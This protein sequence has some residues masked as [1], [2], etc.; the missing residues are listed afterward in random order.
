MTLDSRIELLGKLGDKL[1]ASD[2]SLEAVVTK[3]VRENPWFTMDSV[4]KSFDAIASQYL[5]RD[6]LKTWVSQYQIPEEDYKRVA[7][8]LAGNIPM[9]GI[10]DVISVFVSG[11]KALIKLSDK[12]KVL[13]PF[14]ID[15]MISLGPNARDYFEIVPKVSNFDAVIATGSNASGSYF[16]RYFSDVPNIIRKNRNGVAVLYNSV[17]SNELQALGDDIFTHFGLGCRNVSKL[18]LEEGF[19][20][21][22]IFE[23]VLDHGDVISH[24][25]YK[26]NYDYNNALFLLNNESFLTNNFLIL[27]E[28]TSVSS[29]IASLHYEYFKNEDE[30]QDLIKSKET[31]IQC[32]VGHAT[33]DG[34]D[35]IP[36]GQAQYPSI[37]QY[38]DGVDT[39]EFL[40][41][42]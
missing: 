38:A 4:Q 26:N 19:E 37:T 16:E 39:L 35:V 22:R 5:D 8:I 21:Q 3:A 18:Y 9:V 24:H 41:R 34:L 29:R 33:I 13:I 42:I 12:D 25:K 30:L 32:V 20:L 6:K 7:L 28:E 14:L 10:H 27:K 1:T 31:E 23:A 15:T 2:D 36:F 11:N 40:S 17:S